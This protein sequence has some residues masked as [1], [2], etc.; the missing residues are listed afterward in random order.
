ML[1]ERL[2]RPKVDWAA[3]RPAWAGNG[4][5]GDQ[6][7]KSAFWDILDKWGKI[8][9]KDAKDPLGKRASQKIGKQKLG[10]LL[11][12]GDARAAAIV[13]SS[14]EDFAAALQKVIRRYL[15]L[16]KW[17]KTQSIVIGG[18]LSASHVGQ[19]A[20]ARAELLSRAERID[21]DLGMITH[22]PDEA[23]LIG[24][25]HLVPAWMLKGRNGMLALDLGGTNFRAGIVT[26][27]NAQPRIGECARR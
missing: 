27:R 12:D 24:A 17:D 7:S 16:K 20:V 19:L 5:I 18:G 8:S 4:F 11:A 2:D 14:I 6:A 9:K 26:F 25:V 13:A 22:K 21:I 23:G 3:L 1:T 10:K 15:T